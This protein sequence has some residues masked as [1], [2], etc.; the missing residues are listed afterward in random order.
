MGLS[1]AGQ[2]MWRKYLWVL[3]WM[4]AGNAWAGDEVLVDKAW[5]RESVPGQG[6][7][8]L[9]LILTATR[10][11]RLVGVSSPAAA[12]VQ[13]QRVLPRRHRAKVRLLHDLRLP[14]NRAVAFGEHGLALM[15]VGLKQPL[16]AGSFVRINLNVEL[17]HGRVVTLQAEAEVKPL[18]LSYKHYEGREVYDHR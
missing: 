12:A 9:Q 1:A 18:E 3:L 15:L 16:V 5:L 13:I 4:L 2:M 14:R 17:A 7:A 8:S 10:P 11:A 6:S